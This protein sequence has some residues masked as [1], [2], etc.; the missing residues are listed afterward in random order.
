[1][2]PGIRKAWLATVCAAA[3][4]LG[5]CGGG[6]NPG[7]PR[8]ATVASVNAA[9]T[10]PGTAPLGGFSNLVVFGDSLSDDGAY[11]LA[12]YA[13]YGH[14]LQGLPYA[15]GG[16]FTVNGASTG[17]WSGVLA[18][19]LGLTL[20]P[21]LVGYNL[22]V[23]DVFLTPGGITTSQSAAT[24]AFD[25]AAAGKRPDC[26]NFA[27]GGSMVSQASGI[28]HDSGAL[29]FPV[30]Q[31]WQDYLSEFGSFDAWQLVTVLAGSNDVLA[32]LSSVQSAVQRGGAQAQSTAVA[33][34]QAAVGTAADQ[35]A[36]LVDAM[37][38]AGARYVLVFTLPDASLTPYGQSLS[39]ESTCETVNPQTPCYL[40]SNLVQVFN[41]R[42]LDDLQ[43]HPVKMVDGFAL[44]NQ[45]IANPAKFG[46]TNTST[47]WCDPSAPYGTSLLCNVQTP[48]TS[49]GATRANLGSWLFADS[50]HPT[51]AGY[52][53]LANTT[54]QALRSFGW[55]S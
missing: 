6:G 11:T 29:T 18:G 44:L 34:A 41:Q 9:S 53:V 22:G 10:A 54:L 21:N 13:I 14:A 28:G 51:P 27:Q 39:G 32:A 17:N 25:S 20:S 4:V 49:L 5:G 38:Q 7:P 52:Q 31:Q 47:P 3:V 23:G 36:G 26:T 48:A 30:S 50:L 12:A 43:G 2:H 1:M 16:Q 42:L 8:L 35:L 55:T 45:E 15:Y 46:F 40:L 33:Q 19:S 24:C 37:L